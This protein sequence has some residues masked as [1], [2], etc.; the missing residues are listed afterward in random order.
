MINEEELKMP[1]FDF[2]CTDCKKEFETLTT[3]ANIEEVECPACGSKHVNRLISTFAVGKGSA[4]KSA[5]SCE[6]GACPYT[7][8]CANGM[9]GLN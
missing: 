9:C 2:R 4:S 1:L 7:S 5:S 6:S 3:S 8:P